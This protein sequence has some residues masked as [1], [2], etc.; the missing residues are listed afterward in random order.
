MSSPSNAPRSA[1]WGEIT[2]ALH[3][4]ANTITVR[5]HYPEGHPA[6]VHADVLAGT[7]FVRLLERYPEL[8]VALIDGEFVVN[9]RPLPGLRERLHTLAGAMTRHEIECI[10]FQRGMLQPE[11]G[12]LGRALGRLADAPGKVRETAQAELP[13]V[14]LRFVELKKGEERAALATSA[15]YFV[16]E[17]AELL[18]RTAEVVATGAPIDKGRVVAMAKEI[19]SACSLRVFVLTQRAWTRSAE[20]G[21]THAT[22]VA[23]IVAAMALENDL[24]PDVTLDLT[25]AALVHDIGHWLLPE[26]I[27]GLP[28]PLVTEKDRP[29]FKNHTYAGASALLASGAPPLWIAAALEHHRGVDGGGYP[30]LTTSAP[31]HELVRMIALANFYDRKRTILEG[32]VAMPDE[33]LRQATALEERYFGRPLVERFVRALG[34]FP[35]G[36]TVELSNRQPGL[37]VGVN[38]SDPWRPRVLVLRGE[39]AG[40]R[41]DLKELESN[42]ARH[43]LS[44]VRAILP[45]LFVLADA[46]ASAQDAPALAAEASPAAARSGP[47]APPLENLLERL[48][49]PVTASFSTLP[50]AA[51]LSP[52]PDRGGSYTITRPPTEGDST[53]PALMEEVVSFRPRARSSPSPPSSARSP[54]LSS[55]KVPP[56]PPPRISVLGD[57]TLGS[58]PIPTGAKNVAGGALDHRG[59]FVLGFI[60]GATSVE[61]LAD[62]SGLPRADV[63]GIVQDLVTA[64]VCKLR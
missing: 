28:E 57:V 17:V 22:N 35:P 43:T 33:I 61:D 34:V 47:P 8:V 23:M 19:L 58:V 26:G 3:L 10:V 11:C 29:L 27:R 24:P 49:V 59:A 2:E 51:S 13:H 39:G 50:A 15:A 36:T 16:P 4:V 55:V 5:T 1:D 25:A 6:I 60:D 12:I 64:G 56:L 63:L 32:R 31:P 37:V 21:A 40:S 14:L 38:P 44:I 54:S 41:V 46:P 30:A 9:E 18:A 53:R 42:A 45:P 7:A 20:E 52:R 48:V 62:L